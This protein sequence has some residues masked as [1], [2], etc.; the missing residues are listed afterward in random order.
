MRICI[1]LATFADLQAL[2]VKMKFMEMFRSAYVQ[3]MYVCT[4]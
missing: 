3:C 4:Q 2:I 1:G